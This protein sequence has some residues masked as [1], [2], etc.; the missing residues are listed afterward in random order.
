MRFQIKILTKII[1]TVVENIN[2][3]YFHHIIIFI[4][5]MLKFS[6]RHKLILLASPLSIVIRNLI[7]KKLFVNFYNW[8]S[9]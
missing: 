9:V 3:Y 6:I 5:K 1:Q 2:E 7:F 4:T 8:I